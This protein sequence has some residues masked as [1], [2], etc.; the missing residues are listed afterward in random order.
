R[1]ADVRYISRTM[2]WIPVRSFSRPRFRFWTETRRI[3]SLHE[4]SK[5]SIAS[6][7]KPSRWCSPGDTGLKDEQLCAYSARRHLQSGPKYLRCRCV[8]APDSQGFGAG[9]SGAAVFVLLPATSLF[10]IVA[11]SAA[12]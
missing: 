9:S 7:A 2:G 8:F 4:F 1:S 3:H 5:K 11:G 12:A 6:I 10:G